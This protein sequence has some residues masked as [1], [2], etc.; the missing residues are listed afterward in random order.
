M[1]PVKLTMRNFM[2]YRDGVPPLSFDGLHLAC[3]SGE[4][5]SGK[6]ALIDAMTWALWGKA[7]TTGTKISDDELIAS[8]KAEM[9]VD[10]EFAVGQQHYRIIRK[11]SR[12]KKAGGAGQSLLE[13]Q[14]ADGDGFRAISGDGKAQTQQR[15]ID[16]LHMDYDTFINSAYLRQGHADEFT[17]KDPSKRKEVLAQI[18]GLALYDELE[19]RAREMARQRET[20]RLQV[21][22][23]LGGLSEEL[24]R[25]PAYEA[26]LEQAQN[27]L[28]RT[29]ALMQAKDAALN[30]LRQQKEALQNKKTQLDELEARLGQNASDLERW[31]AQAGQ[32]R[33]RIKEHEAVISRRPAIEEGFTRFT[34]ARQINEELDKKLRQSA[35]LEKTRAQLEK[36]LQDS[37]NELKTSHAVTQNRMGELA[38]RVQKLPDL[39]DRL[40]QA[41]GQLR[42]LDEQEAA[43]Q[44]QEEAAQKLQAAVN[45]LEAAITRL[46]RE[47]AG[48]AEKLDLLAT[49]TEAKCPLCGTAL[50]ADGLEHIAAEYTRDRQTKSDLLASTRAE[51]AQKQNELKARQQA[52]SLASRKMNAEKTQAQSQAEIIKNDIAAAE[53]AAGQLAELKAALADIERHLAQRDFA[54][55]D[56]RKLEAVEAELASLGY[57]AEKHEQVRQQLQHLGNFEADKRRLEEAERLMPQERE[58]ALNAEKAAQELRD[59]IAVSRRQK[60]ALAAELTQLPQ[61]QQNLAAA[62]RENPSQLSVSPVIYN[63]QMVQ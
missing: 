16:T 62:E 44:P 50:T 6:S 40:G 29:A 31:Q 23:T 26:E 38:A 18:L 47:I 61:V 21:E 14:V 35:S 11:R 34:E 63:S 46:E 25:R 17:V 3:L 8:G 45:H 53:E 57:D 19:E 1:I 22:S 5:G 59:R 49:Q 58:T 60:E 27:E 36:R 7:R 43:R 56:Q 48:T 42:Q 4:N 32:H 13:F 41:Q 54:V 55:D 51:L 39:K 33:S 15:I 12:P 28:A 30:G 24:A 2:C 10:F 52:V 9:E 37:L 20:E